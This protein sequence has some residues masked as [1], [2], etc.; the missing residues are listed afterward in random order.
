MRQ[1][2]DAMAEA[3]RPAILT[4]GCQCGAVR[5]ALYA[6]PDSDICHCRMCQK[7]VGN[8][9]MAVAG[10]PLDQLVWTT[11]EPAL[12]RSSSAAER[13]F[14]RDCGTPLTFRYLAKGSIN[15]TLGS[16]D[17][18]AKARPTIQHGIES[19]VPWWRELFDLPGM[20]TEQD[21]PPGG[22]ETM[23]NYQ[24]RGSAR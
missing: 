18:P 6:E 17:E 1:G 11:G 13:G 5:Y 7:A 8:L 14:C 19:R 16:L 15:V 12:Y 21:P 10:V 3:T 20:T 4:G 9:F 24:H 2:D 23:E 22:L